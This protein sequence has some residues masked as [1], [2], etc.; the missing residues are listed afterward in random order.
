M[1]CLLVFFSAAEGGTWDRQRE[2]PRETEG[3]SSGGRRED[4][5]GIVRDPEQ[6]DE[7]GQSEITG[8]KGRGR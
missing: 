6:D 7:G 5:L 2:S 8:D 1:V 4:S 3:R